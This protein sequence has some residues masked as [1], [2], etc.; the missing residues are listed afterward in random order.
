MIQSHG[1]G[2]YDYKL[3]SHIARTGQFE[4]EISNKLERGTTNILYGWTEIF[5]TPVDWSQDTQHGFLQAVTIGLPYGAV[6]MVGRTVVGVY[7]VATCYAPQKPI[8]API[9][10]D[11]V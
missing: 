8:F 2:S 5:R 7:E 11:I 4:S 3:D 10:G 6:R 1:Y 9:E